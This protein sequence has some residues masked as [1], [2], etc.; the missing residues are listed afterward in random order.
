MIHRITNYE[1]EMMNIYMYNYNHMYYKIYVRVRVVNLIAELCELLRNSCKALFAQSRFV[2]CCVSCFCASS[3]CV[4]SD[5]TNSDSSSFCFCQS[6]ACASSTYIQGD[7]PPNRSISWQRTEFSY[8]SN[9]CVQ[10]F[11]GVL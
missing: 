5:L 2:L 4:W 8:A 6:C 1:I 7:F 9:F 3:N 10:V 11:A